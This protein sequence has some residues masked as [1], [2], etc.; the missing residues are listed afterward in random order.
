MCLTATWEV[1]GLFFGVVVMAIGEGMLKILFL[2]VGWW[3]FL[4]LGTLF[5]LLGGPFT[6]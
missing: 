5:F 6:P 1:W 2:V 4:F 3:L